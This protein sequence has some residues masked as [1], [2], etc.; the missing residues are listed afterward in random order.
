MQSRRQA[1]QE[2]AVARR[3]QHEEELEEEEGRAEAA[4]PLDWVGHQRQEVGG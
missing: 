3:R 2:E 4:G 1:E